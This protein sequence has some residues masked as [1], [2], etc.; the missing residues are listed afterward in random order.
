MVT[1]ESRCLVTTSLSKK[2]KRKHVALSK[3]K[4]DCRCRKL[5]SFLSQYLSAVGESERDCR[6][7]FEQCRLSP[8]PLGRPLLSLPKTNMKNKGS[9]NVTG[10]KFENRTRTQ[11]R[12]RSPI[13]S[14]LET[15]RF[16]LKQL[17]AL[18]RVPRQSLH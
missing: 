12:T 6:H 3:V 17:D 5:S 2:A 1:K 9:G 10:L 16:I 18:L 7:I 11:S 13:Y 4:L 15:S 14:S 8:K